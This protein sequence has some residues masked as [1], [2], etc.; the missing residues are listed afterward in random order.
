MGSSGRSAWQEPIAD[1]AAA[2]QDTSSSVPSHDACCQPSRRKE[3]EVS[4]RET[5]IRWFLACP[6]WLLQAEQENGVAEITYEDSAEFWHR[7]G[8]AA[9][10]RVL[11]PSTVFPG[12]QYSIDRTATHPSRDRLYRTS[13]FVSFLL[14]KIPPARGRGGSSSSDQAG[15]ASTMLT[16]DAVEITFDNERPAV[17]SR[18]RY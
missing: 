12:P 4:T 17:S 14:F 16:R 10:A 1:I 5:C 6:T 8:R 9:L 3:G 13:R 2:D 15:T 7:T 18:P 11:F